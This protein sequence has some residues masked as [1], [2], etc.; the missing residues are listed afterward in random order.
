MGPI[1]VIYIIYANIVWA[2]SKVYM[3]SSFVLHG[4]IIKLY[5]MYTLLADGP[6]SYIYNIC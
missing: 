3:Q 2:H 6:N 1:I 5:M 4:P